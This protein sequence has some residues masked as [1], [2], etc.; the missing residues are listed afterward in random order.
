LPAGLAGGV[1]HAARGAWHALP[2]SAHVY[3]LL[4]AAALAAEKGGDLG[5][6]TSR[7]ML[8]AFGAAGLV[9]V[10]P[11]M[12]AFRRAALPLYER[13]V[14]AHRDVRAAIDDAGD[15]IEELG[16]PR[17]FTRAQ[18]E[19]GLFEARGELRR[20]L[21]PGEGPAALARAQA[22]DD[23][24]GPGLIPGAA[25]RPLAQDFVLP[26]LALVAGPG[27]IAYLAQLARAARLLEVTP[28]AI[29]P[30]W[31]ATWLP[32]AAIEVCAE[33]DVAPRDL[34][35]APDTAL[36]AFLAS[37][38][39]RSLSKPLADLRA[40]AEAA[41]ARLAKEA[42]ALDKSL[43]ELVHATARRIDWRL[44]RLAEG[45]G[46]KARR[47]W[48]RA[49]P[50]GAHLVSYVRPNG[51]LQERTLAWL[52]IVARGG[53][54]A[55]ESAKAAAAAHVDLALSGKTLAHDI[56]ALEANGE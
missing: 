11:R 19:F 45:F 50:E 49:H 33:A 8:E 2:G 30:R 5:D 7:L 54:A 31:S 4:D 6:V 40:Q 47:A 23:V 29:F 22:A 3:A 1:W 15:T 55:E 13:Y 25:L 38:V 52:D 21:S 14:A 37:G 16:L 42:P 43:P 32:R 10:D 20:H 56:L 18:T 46:R 27:E 36:A 53:R 48:K 39:P 35:R 12:P 51:A 28:A 17:G 41:F 26:T 34:V 44:G 24:T 9:V